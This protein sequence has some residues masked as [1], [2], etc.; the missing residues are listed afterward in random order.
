MPKTKRHRINNRDFC[1]KLNIS[2]PTLYNWK[3]HKPLLYDVVMAYKDKMFSWD[4]DGDK[5]GALLKH[6]TNLSKEEQDYYVSEIK[7]RALRRAIDK[8]D[9]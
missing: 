1:V 6:F 7:T 5:E 8:E 3:K 9:I 4:E 2:E